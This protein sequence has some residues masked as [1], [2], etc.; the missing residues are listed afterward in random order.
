MGGHGAVFALRRALGGG[1]QGRGGRFAEGGAAVAGGLTITF[2]GGSLDD[3]TS[4][5]RRFWNVLLGS[6]RNGTNLIETQFREM[7]V[8]TTRSA[9]RMYRDIR[10]SV[11]DIQNS[12]KVRGDRIINSWADMFKKSGAK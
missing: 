6:A 7:R 10:G 1:G 12:F 5:W 8:N 9:D 11:A 3:F 2:Q 4:A